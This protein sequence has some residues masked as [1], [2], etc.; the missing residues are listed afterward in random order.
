[1]TITLCHLE[2]NTEYKVWT[3]M[4]LKLAHGE[5]INIYF[6]KKL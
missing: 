6:I 2:L 5:Q 4:C 3:Q 1:M